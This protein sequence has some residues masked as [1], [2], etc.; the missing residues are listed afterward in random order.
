MT[1][2]F[3]VL[4]GLMYPEKL[5]IT[6]KTRALKKLAS[7]L[8]LSVLSTYAYLEYFYFRQF[9]DAHPQTKGHKTELN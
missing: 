7:G 4:Y 1:L 6:Y 8:I 3:P 2:Q 5:I 9:C